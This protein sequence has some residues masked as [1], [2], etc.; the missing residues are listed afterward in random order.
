M[1]VKAKNMYLYIEATYM[2][3]SSEYHRAII[4]IKGT[5]IIDFLK[6]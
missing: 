6:K 2:I 3:R 1:R 5:L 4:Q